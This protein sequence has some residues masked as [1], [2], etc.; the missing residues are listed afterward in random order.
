MIWLRDISQR[1]ASRRVSSEPAS[2]S[3][4][5]QY[6]SYA[7]LSSDV[8]VEPR[9]GRD[10]Q[11][12]T[13]AA[14]L[15]VSIKHVPSASPPP[16]VL[17]APQARSST[18]FLAPSGDPDDIPNPECSIGIKSVLNGEEQ[19]MAIR[20]RKLLRDRG[21]DLHLLAQVS[22]D[23]IFQVRSGDR[24]AKYAL[25]GRFAQKRVDLLIV[26]A[27][28]RPLLGIEY[29]GTGHRQGNYIERD[30]S[31]ASIFERAGLPLFQ[32]PHDAKW[33]FLVEALEDVLGSSL[34]PKPPSHTSPQAC[35]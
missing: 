9:I 34:K 12:Q 10:H 4:P 28:M 2:Y 23:E 24:K 21:G 30:A 17:T 31:K 27:S 1:K 35:A 26:D 7:E 29:Q 13:P 19:R 33:P 11:T 16:K 5:Y 8:V 6:G 22:L 20:I 32:V 18:R 15:P 25:R 3:I 14:S